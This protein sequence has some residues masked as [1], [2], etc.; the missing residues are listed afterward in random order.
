MLYNLLAGGLAATLETLST[1]QH[2]QAWETEF[3]SVHE[4]A[5]WQLYDALWAVSVEL[6]PGLEPTRRHALID[7]LL[8]PVR[9][10][11]VHSAARMALVIRLFQFLLVIRLAPLLP[12][13]RAGEQAAVTE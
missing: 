8:S 2:V 5:V 13:I 9:D 11:A 6:Q 10:P 12:T 7:S 1:L 3:A 4:E